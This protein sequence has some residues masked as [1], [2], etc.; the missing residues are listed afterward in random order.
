[1]LSFGVFLL[2]QVFYSH[3]RSGFHSVVLS[4]YCLVIRRMHCSFPARE[5][6]IFLAHLFLQVYCLQ[7]G[8]AKLPSLVHFVETVL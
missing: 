8:V 5:E 4:P 6:Q 7:S 3:A 1:M 2:R